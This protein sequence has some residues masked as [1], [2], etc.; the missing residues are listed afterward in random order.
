MLR[1]RSAVSGEMMMS[2]NAHE[3]E[4]K[5]VKDLKRQVARQIGASRFRQ[6][7]FNEEH[8][9]LQDEVFD[10][11][12]SEVQLVVLDLMPFENKQEEIEFMDLCR[13]NEVDKVEALLLRPFDPKTRDDLGRSACH[14]AALAGYGEWECLSLVIEA[15]AE[16]DAEDNQGL[17]PLH[18][19]SEINQVE[20]VRVLLH[21][22]ADINKASDSSKAIP[23]VGLRDR[24][25]AVRLN[26]SNNLRDPFDRARDIDT[27]HAPT[28]L[29]FAAERGY[30]NVV[31]LL[32]ESEADIDKVT[33]KGASSLQLALDYGQKHVAKLLLESRADAKK[34]TDL[35]STALHL[36][37]R[38][39]DLEMV[40]LLLAAGVDK[41]HSTQL[42]IT[43][44]YLAAAEGH[45]EVVESLLVTPVNKDVITKSGLTALHAAA[46]GGHVEVVQLL[47]KAAVDPNKTSSEGATALHSAAAGGHLEVVSLLLE[48]GCE[49]SISCWSV[50]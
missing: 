26:R 49:M 31:R 46:E 20:A 9:E 48:A 42:G 37:S 28:A 6:R 39:G 4:G 41:D 10:L 18:L 29:H 21:A 19:A 2:F 12:A 14:W 22:R 16:I 7:W 11:S 33:K 17:T 50:G 35:G 1:V 47:L 3:I 34:T 30:L 15:G 25:R 45:L 36:A 13:Q 38:R 43:A 23:R 40:R 44:L 24:F 8:Q 32:L 27:S 5:V